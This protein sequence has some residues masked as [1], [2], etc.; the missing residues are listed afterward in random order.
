M[1]DSEVGKTAATSS[2]LFYTT[3]FYKIK[4]ID[5]PQSSIASNYII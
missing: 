1:I 4:L 3:N 5:A 2:K